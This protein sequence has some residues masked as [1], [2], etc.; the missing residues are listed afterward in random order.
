MANSERIRKAQRQHA[1][2]QG[3]E[4]VEVLAGA[5][6]VPHARSLA[7]RVLAYDSSPETR[8]LL[9]QRLAKV[10]HPEVLEGLPSP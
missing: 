8:S 1:V 5:G 9:Q 6:D 7:A 2:K 10:G 3:V 4:G